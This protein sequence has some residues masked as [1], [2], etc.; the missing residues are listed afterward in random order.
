MARNASLDFV[1]V[2]GDLRMRGCKRYHLLSIESAP[3]L[4]EEPMRYRPVLVDM[5]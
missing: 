1:A 2:L 4:E 5:E 3:F